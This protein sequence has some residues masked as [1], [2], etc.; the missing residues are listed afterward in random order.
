MIKVHSSINNNISSGCCS[1]NSF[2]MGVRLLLIHMSVYSYC[3]ALWNPMQGSKI[4]QVDSL[5]RNHITTVYFLQVHDF[6]FV[7]MIS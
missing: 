2:S 4:A 7:V 3:L 5:W 1:A 6:N